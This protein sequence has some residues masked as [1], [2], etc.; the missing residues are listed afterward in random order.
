MKRTTL[1]IVFALAMTF[2]S[3]AQ[4]GCCYKLRNCAFVTV[5]DVGDIKTTKYRYNPTSVEDET[6]LP[7]MVGNKAVFKSRFVEWGM[8]SYPQVFSPSGIKIALRIRF[9]SEK[10][11]AKY[12]W[13][14]LLCGLSL[15]II[16]AC[17]KYYHSISV[18]LEM[19]D[20]ETTNENY[21]LER[22]RDFSEGLF[23]FS[24]YPLAGQRM[25][26]HIISNSL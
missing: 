2:V 5:N 24:L 13:T 8:R 6:E 20:D 14:Q 3:F 22:S 17:E 25:L 4:Y 21:K 9:D 18:E 10:S 11:G 26:V 7:T 12:A 16:P 19:V 15:F 23:P 1:R